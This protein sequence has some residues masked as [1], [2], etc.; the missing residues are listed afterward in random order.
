MQ[1]IGVPVS[2]RVE[3]ETLLFKHIPSSG[4]GNKFYA[5]VSP[6][7]GNLG[8]FCG[9]WVLKASVDEQYLTRGTFF[10]FKNIEDAIV[11][12]RSRFGQECVVPIYFGAVPPRG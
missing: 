5:V 3:E 7:A 9:W 8:V 6:A 10:A 12:Y 1:V 2:H 11:R 4:H